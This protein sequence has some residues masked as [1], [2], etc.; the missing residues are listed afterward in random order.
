M[1]NGS[2][3]LRPRV[4]V[5]KE[6]QRCV[7]MEEVS[8][9]RKVRDGDNDPIQV[10]QANRQNVTTSSFQTRTS[11]VCRIKSGVG[12]VNAATIV[13]MR[14]CVNAVRARVQQH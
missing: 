3:R 2:R 4:S 11:F 5:E 14:C 12:N 13:A 10:R 1:K 8:G 6:M 7:C 9:I